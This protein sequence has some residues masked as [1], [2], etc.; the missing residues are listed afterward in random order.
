M[1]LFIPYRN[2]VY[3]P[4][5]RLLSFPM[6]E[7]NKLQ[8]LN[9]FK[10][11][12]QFELYAKHAV[13]GFITGL[14]KSPFHGFSVE[15][16]EHKIYNPGESTKHIDWKL[17]G[18]TDRLY[19]KRYE[20]ETNLRCHLV[21][22]VSNSMFY[23]VAQ[24]YSMERPN[25]YLFSAISAF[26]LMHLLRKQRDAVGLQ[27]FGRSEYHLKAKGGLPH[28]KIIAH[29]LWKYIEAFETGQAST[30]S[31]ENTLHLMAERIPK[32][33]LICIF[34]DFFDLQDEEKFE[35]FFKAIQHLKYQKHEVILFWT[36]Q[37][38]EE[39][40]FAFEERPYRFVD[41]ESG[42]TVKLN[43]AELK[44]EYVN[45]L[46][47]FTHKL[48]SYCTQHRIELVHCA[49]E[50]GVDTVLRAFLSKRKKMF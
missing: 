33:G 48:G 18:R 17:Y 38:E 7:E 26:S 44:K 12:S 5:V 47:A 11:F 13:E 27:L 46:E 25:K 39:L 45:R 4:Y 6:S 49:I 15:F 41:L 24:R 22:D 28:Q 16:S 9:Q 30:F 34:S 23:P 50:A 3:S 10:S 14:H 43:P 36:I 21:L 20:E 31:A 29:E 1:A 8:D 42:Q 35:G 40:A 37:Q 32:R 19:T 2:I